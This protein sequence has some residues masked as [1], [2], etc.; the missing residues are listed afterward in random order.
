MNRNDQP[1]AAFVDAIARS[2]YTAVLSD[3]LDELGYRRQAFPPS[4]RPLDDERTL[5]GFARTGIYREVHHA[6]VD[7]NPYELEIA[8]IDDLRAHDVVVLGCG[9]SQCIAPWGELLTTASRARGASGC[10]TDGYV[11][12]I[13]AIRKL[14][15]PVYHGGIAPLDSKGRGKIA[16]IDVPIV[17]AGVDVT[18]GDLVVGDADGIV[19]VPQRVEAVTLDNALKKVDGE[20][21]T[22]EALLRGAALRDVFAE[23]NVL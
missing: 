5:V 14:G 9:G 10:V 15:F 23:Y 13:R 4:I 1:L 20:D 2:L 8:L 19:V 3:V 12:D 21:K 18:P 17:C 22:R 11:R 6:L 16:E 7:A